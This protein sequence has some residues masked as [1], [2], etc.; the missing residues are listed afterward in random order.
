MEFFFWDS[1]KT[2]LLRRLSTTITLV[3]N[4]SLFIFIRHSTKEPVPVAAR[5]KA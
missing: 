3:Y 2:I 4:I 1:E 5:S